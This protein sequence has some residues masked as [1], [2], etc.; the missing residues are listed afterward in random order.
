MALTPKNWKDFQHY[1][2]RKPVWIKLHRS[3]LDD[4]AFLRLPLASQALAPRLWLL[5]SEYEGG[6]ITASMDEIAFRVRCD[7]SELESALK[8]LINS[9]FFIDDSNMLAACEQPACLEKSR[10]Q[11]KKEK[12]SCAVAPAT[13]TAKNLE[14]EEFWKAYPKRQ[15]ANPKHP[16]RKKFEAL[17]KNGL[18]SE[19]LISAARKY[20]DG[21]AALGHIGTPYVAQAVTWLNQQ[22]FED[23]QLSSEDLARQLS[24]D[25]DM[26]GRGYVWLNGSWIKEENVRHETLEPRPWKT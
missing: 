6:A 17:V 21:E 18:S 23:Y 2:E 15:G 12:E 14:F 1:K 20:A 11:V 25:R 22:R 5:A 7:I 3:L 26:A 16:A 13:R 24:I 19:V 9:G 10:E 8:P 4:Y